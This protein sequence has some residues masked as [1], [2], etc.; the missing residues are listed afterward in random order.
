M[1]LLGWLAAAW[2]GSSALVVNST[3]EPVD[4]EFVLVGRTVCDSCSGPIAPG[5]TRSI[6]LDDAQRLIIDFVSPLGQST[7]STR[8]HANGR[9]TGS[10]DGLLVEQTWSQGPDGT[11]LVLTV[12]SD[13]AA[14][15]R[16]RD[17]VG[18]ACGSMVE[19]LKGC[20]PT[21][22]HD[23]FSM[24]QVVEQPDG[25]CH[26]GDGRPAE[27]HLPRSLLRRPLSSPEAGGVFAAD[28]GPHGA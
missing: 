28:D 9:S 11:T 4:P 14:R 5:D 23:G 15:I 26:P 8:W 2:A 3:D 25:S 6:D 1:D 17:P 20:R 18:P 22:C 10:S 27:H 12:G 21:L 7:V 19:E 24:V 16:N 13:P